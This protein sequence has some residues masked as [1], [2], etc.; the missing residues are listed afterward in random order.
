VQYAGWN[1]QSATRIERTQAVGARLV[2]RTPL[3]DLER[4][5]DRPGPGASRNGRLPEGVIA[6]LLRLDAGNIGWGRP[7]TTVTVWKTISTRP[8]GCGLSHTV[9][10]S[11][12][13]CDLPLLPT[14][15]GQ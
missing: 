7:A 5:V 12:M 14:R 10:V 13:E 3:G 6:S 4:G 15:F 2:A 11:Y 9:V 1:G 8:V